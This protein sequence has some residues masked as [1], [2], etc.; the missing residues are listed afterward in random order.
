MKRCVLLVGCF[1]FFSATV[2]SATPLPTAQAYSRSIKAAV[3]Q[4]YQTALKT[5]K[6]TADPKLI[7][8][9]E[10][11]RLT[12]SQQI[13]D[14]NDAQNFIRKNPGWP[15]IYLIRRNAELALLETGKKSDLEKWFEQHPPVS[16]QAVL[17]YADILMEKKEWENAQ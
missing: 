14:F 3:S 7:K 10:W 5:A 9:I 15:R 1:Y 12:D 2:C 6:T 17:T 4:D 11:F 13:P 8:L 16:T